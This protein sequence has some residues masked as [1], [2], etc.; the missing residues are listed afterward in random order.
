MSV[1]VALTE[2]LTFI[3]NVTGLVGGFRRFKRFWLDERGTRHSNG[4]RY[5]DDD[6]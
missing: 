6:T 4:Q 3:G 5:E 1:V 2:V